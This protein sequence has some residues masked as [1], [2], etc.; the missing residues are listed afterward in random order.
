MTAPSEHV[1]EVLLEDSLVE[2]WPDYP[3]LYDVRSPEFKNR[4]Y[5]EKALK[6]IAGQLNTTGRCMHLHICAETTI[7]LVCF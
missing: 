6:E 5:R 2:I 4:D 3:C 1:I 7:A